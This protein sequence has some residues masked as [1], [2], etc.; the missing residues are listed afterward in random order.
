MSSFSQDEFDGA[1]EKTTPLMAQ[2]A[3]E[4]ADDP[5]AGMSGGQAGRSGV[6]GGMLVLLGVIVV[7]GGTLFMM[8]KYGQGPGVSI[9]DVKIDYPLGQQPG[10]DGDHKRVLDDLKTI[11]ET[12]PIPLVEVRQNPFEMV[13][14]APDAEEVVRTGE[15]EAD[16]LRREAEA[17]RARVQ[18][19]F[20]KLQLATVLSGSSPV[21][22]ISG[23]TVRVGDTVGEF[24]TVVAIHDRSVDLRADGQ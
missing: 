3:E 15:T 4:G 9:A 22:R 19:A 2:I 14:E 7:A 16:R 20:E 5:L 6:G 18:A 17:R 24:F 23:E 13:G 11:D 1:D 12:V 21:A 8:R 10:A